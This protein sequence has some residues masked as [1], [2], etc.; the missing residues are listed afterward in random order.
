M[1]VRPLGRRRFDRVYSEDGG[2]RHWRDG[3]RGS[4]LTGA[5]SPDVERPEER[6]GPAVGSAG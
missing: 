2:D 5:G 1:S 4:I 6:R 3:D